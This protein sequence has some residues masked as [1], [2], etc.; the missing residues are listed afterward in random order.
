MAQEDEYVVVGRVAGLYGVR[1]WIRV[2]SFTQ[3]PE[4]ILG[5]APWYLEIQGGWVPSEPAD[6]KA[7]GKGMVARLAGCDDRDAAAR[8]VGAAIAVRRGQLP[9]PGE[10]EYY[11]SDLI[12][13]RVVNRQ[14]VE[15]GR[16][17][18][19]ME[20][21]ANDVLVVEGERERLIPV[22]AEALVG[23]DLEAGLITVDWDPDF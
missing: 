13:L 2:E 22:T 19:L 16:V 11:W 23:V 21:G 12:G 9:E 17:A 5:Y 15:F 4:N 3:P 18:S 7:H 1:G 20:T 8:L 14:G 6:G 10:G